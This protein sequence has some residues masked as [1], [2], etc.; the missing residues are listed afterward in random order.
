MAETDAVIEY[1]D[2]TGGLHKSLAPHRIPDNALQEAKNIIMVNDS[3]LLQRPAIT[4]WTRF[5]DEENLNQYLNYIRD[6]AELNYAPDNIEHMWL[7]AVINNAAIS[8]AINLLFFIKTDASANALYLWGAKVTLTTS[9]E[10]DTGALPGGS[11]LDAYPDVDD[12]NSWLNPLV[13]TYGPDAYILA[14][15]SIVKLDPTI[16]GSTTIQSTSPYD[17]IHS[18]DFHKD[19]LFWAGKNS[20]RLNYSEI[21][22]PLTDEGYID[23]YESSAEIHAIKSL[24]DVLYISTTVGMYGLYVQGDVTDWVLRKIAAY[25]C[26]GGPKSVVTYNNVLY[27]ITSE[28]IISTDGTSFE[29]ISV[30]IYNI[31]R[32]TD[33]GFP[34]YL[35]TTLSR[36]YTPYEVAVIDFRILF[37]VPYLDDSDNIQWRYLVWDTRYSIWTEWVFEKEPIGFLSSSRRTANTEHEIIFKYKDSADETQELG[38]YSFNEDKFRD[39]YYQDSNIQLP[40]YYPFTIDIRTKDLDFQLPHKYKRFKWGIVEVRGISV[41]INYYKDFSVNSDL[42]HPISPLINTRFNYK[43]IPKSGSFILL[44]LEINTLSYP[45]DAYTETYEDTYGDLGNFDPDTDEK[46]ENRFAFCGFTFIMDERNQHHEGV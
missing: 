13:L 14:N 17:S 6:A 35:D 43:K 37:K 23:I 8:R 12:I 34:T 26:I 4:A 27:F 19:R 16:E 28:G 15:T 31:L 22:T 40:S 29:N 41:S 1:K 2:F 25:Y 46:E 33:A 32:D 44:S 11:Q 21:G 5:Y 36:Y 10:L 3:V 7:V 18:G 24:G 9:G 39:E 30:P 42:Q 38:I 45:E 20:N